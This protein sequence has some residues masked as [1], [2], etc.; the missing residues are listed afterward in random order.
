MSPLP[1]LNFQDTCASHT[2]KPAFGVLVECVVNSLNLQ[3]QEQTHCTL[4]MNS[5]CI[6]CVGQ[7]LPTF[8][9]VSVA[10]LARL[11]RQVPWVILSQSSV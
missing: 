1:R 7:V 8:S 3:I 11:I 6:L 5:C 4:Q 9:A 10:D 2:Q